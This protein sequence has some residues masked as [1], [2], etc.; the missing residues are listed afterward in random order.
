M[1]PEVARLRVYDSSACC[2][3][4]YNEDNRPGEVWMPFI[5]FAATKIADSSV[6]FGRCASHVQNASASNR[7]LLL[8]V[9]LR[10]STALQP[11]MV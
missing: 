9:S 5:L 6:C 2:A 7:F 11:R 1:F 10:S 3:G 8:S 4:Y